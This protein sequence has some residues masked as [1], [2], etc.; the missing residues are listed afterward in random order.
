MK[1][2]GS[3]PG[4]FSFTFVQGK[5]EEFEKK[6]ENIEKPRSFSGTSIILK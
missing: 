5:K 1:K 6:S 2:P 3:F 4:T